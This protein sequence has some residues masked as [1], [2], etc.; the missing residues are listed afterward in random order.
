MLLL[1]DVQG[2]FFSNSAE[3]LVDD[4]QE[5][6]HAHEHHHEDEQTEHQWAQKRGRTAQLL[7]IEFHE[8][9]LEQHLR[10]VQ[11]GRARQQ[12]SH[13]QQIGQC[14]ERPEYHREHRYERRQISGRMLKCVHEE[15]AQ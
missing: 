12:L 8:G 6:A 9:H 1:V 14:D 3:T 11:Q 15:G 10:R 5:H 7:S 2:G 13:E 4:R